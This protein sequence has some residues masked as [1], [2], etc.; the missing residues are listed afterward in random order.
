MVL[1]GKCQSNSLELTNGDSTKLCPN[2]LSWSTGLNT[3]GGF[4]ADHSTG[5]SLFPVGKDN[6]VTLTENTSHVEG[7]TARLPQSFLCSFLECSRFLKTPGCIFSMFRVIKSSEYMKSW[8]VL[9]VFPNSH[10]EN[11]S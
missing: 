9:A 2:T 7:I 5:F 11:L 8:E 4:L 1:K 6:T 10:S 3:I